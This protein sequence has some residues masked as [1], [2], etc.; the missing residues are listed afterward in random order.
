MKKIDYKV[1]CEEGF[2]RDLMDSIPDVIYFKDKSGKLVLVNKAHAKGLGLRPEEVI[3]KTDF[4]IFSKERAQKMLEDDLRVIKTER[5]II[6]KVER[7]TRAD[8]IDNYVST[9]KIPRYDKKGKIIGLIGITRDITKRM[10][11]ERLKNENAAIEKRLQ[12]MQ[13]LNQLKSEFISIV[14]HELRTPLAIVK[15]SLLLITDEVCGP[16]TQK[17]RLVLKNANEN[18]HRLKGLIDDLLDI[19]RIEGKRLKLHY[20][21]VNLN[22]LLEGSSDFFKKLAKEKNIELEYLLP[23][24]QVNIF[25]DA[26]RINQVA[27]NLINNAIKFTESGGR[28]KVEVKILENKVRVGI[29]DSGIGISKHDLGK[30][31]NKFV[32][33]SRDPQMQRKGLGL[34]VYIAKE[35]V[36][37]HG[38]EIWAESKLGVGSKFYFTLPGFYARNLLDSQ[39]RGE[40]NELLY[41]GTS[42][43]LISILF[44]NFIRLRRQLPIKPVKF[45][46]EIKHIINQVLTNI[47]F[48]AKKKPRVLLIDFM[49]GEISIVFPKATEGEAERLCAVIRD[50]IYKYLKEKEIG[51]IFVNLAVLSYNASGKPNTNQE[52]LANLN[53]KKLYIG[54]EIRRHKRVNYETAIEVIWGKEKSE[55]VQTIDISEGGLCF[56]SKSP[57]ETD[58]RV[59]IKLKLLAKS[60][61]MRLEGRVAWIKNI[62]EN[63]IKKGTGRY[64]IGLEFSGLS[65]NNRKK[66]AKFIRTMSAA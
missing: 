25:I 39:V 24:K 62:V 23:K 2:F 35:L 22:E 57:L 8:G 49:N 59:Q 29:I 14:S 38:G 6:D 15:E 56:T 20:S 65:P 28:I 47:H 18:V 66:L 12:A 33:V 58:S 36:E 3:G 45:F 42:L 48:A 51:G 32:Q 41:R 17:Q 30:L 54:S 26:E 11:I 46:E 1:L 44:V 61:I 60:G 64:K 37:L 13:E 34:G 52:L 53:I 4:D 10:H 40:I 16:V 31:F 7:A 21:L 9:T 19:S 43:Y 5:P 63:K 50:R 55:L 27:T